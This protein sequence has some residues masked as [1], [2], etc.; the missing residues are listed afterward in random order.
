MIL[1]HIA[2]FDRH[3]SRPLDRIQNYSSNHRVT[4]R[5]SDVLYLYR[6]PKPNASQFSFESAVSTESLRFIFLWLRMGFPTAITP[7]G[8]SLL[9][10]DLA[11][12]TLPSPTVTPVK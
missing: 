7:C 9:T 12:I 1:H 11:P 10:N 3:E 4:P 6:E 8:M 5:G 2:H